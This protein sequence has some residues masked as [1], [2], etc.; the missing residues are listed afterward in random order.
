[1]SLKRGTESV[2]GILLIQLILHFDQWKG[3]IKTMAEEEEDDLSG[4][5]ARR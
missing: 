1:M 3:R 5:N 2:N 4:S